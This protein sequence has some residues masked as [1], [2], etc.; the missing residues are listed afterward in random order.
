MAER[1]ARLQSQLADFEAEMNEWRALHPGLDPED[2]PQGV[3]ELQA[4]IDK[5]AW[6][7]ADLE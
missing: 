6:D 3:R 4:Y 1:R 2:G 7:L 5:A